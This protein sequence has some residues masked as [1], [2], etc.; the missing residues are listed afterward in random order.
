MGKT[1]ESHVTRFVRRLG[2]DLRLY[3]PASSESA[4]LMKILSVHRINLVFDVGANAGH[5]GQYLRDAGYRGRIVSFEPLATPWEGLLEASRKDPLW[6]VAPRAAIGSDEGEVDIH[7]ARNSVSSSILA[8]HDAHTKAAPASGY[9]GKERVSIRR[10]DSLALEY[11]HSDS[12]PFLKIDT[13]GY[14]NEVLSGADRIMDRIVGIQLELS[15]VPLYR[16][17][18]L[19]DDLTECLKRLGFELWAMSP[20]LVDPQSGRLL[21]YDATFFRCSQKKT[22]H[23]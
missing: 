11:L 18:R 19:W 23:E 7:V 5:F 6:E 3:R 16:G 1:L 14:E 15:L 22:A 12:V 2:F 20:V 8:M 21:Q 10:L 4:Q 13:Q 17:Q 9:I